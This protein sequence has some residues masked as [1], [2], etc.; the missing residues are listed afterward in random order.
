MEEG[1]G[2]RVPGFSLK[3]R[4]FVESVP[5]RI[6]LAVLGQG[7]ASEPHSEVDG[8]VGSGRVLRVVVDGANDDDDGSTA[9]AGEIP[10]PCS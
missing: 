1:G 10:L 3:R 2:Q 8:G 4:V 5:P 6:A 7:A 9:N